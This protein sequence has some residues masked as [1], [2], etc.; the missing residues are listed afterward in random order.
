MD[1]DK[2][3][4]EAMKPPKTGDPLAN[5]KLPKSPYRATWLNQFFAMMRRSFLEVIRDPLLVAVKLGQTMVS[6]MVLM[7]W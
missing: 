2:K 7:G 1:V 3:I 6:W 4:Q 5:I